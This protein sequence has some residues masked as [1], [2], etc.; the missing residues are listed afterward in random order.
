M[1][2]KS[3]PSST[4][5]F[6]DNQIHAFLLYYF[7]LYQPRPSCVGSESEEEQ[8]DEQQGDSVESVSHD[9]Q[10]RVMWSYDT[11]KKA[12]SAIKGRSIFRWNR[13]ELSEHQQRRA[14]SAIETL[15]RDDYA[16]NQESISSN[17]ALGVYFVRRMSRGILQHALNGEKFS[18]DSAILF[19]LA[20]VLQAALNCRLG[21]I[22]ASPITEE[23]PQ[24]QEPSLTYRD[25]ILVL[26][27]GDTIEDVKGEWTIR[28]AEDDE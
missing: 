18:W 8:E 3:P 22:L 26:D 7:A 5:P 13:F 12:V 19:T 9:P 20:I 2:A 27:G 25:V 24:D 10:A 15:L 28:N 1:F 21:D 16:T 23:W 11:L 17:Q 6:E 4:I 14:D